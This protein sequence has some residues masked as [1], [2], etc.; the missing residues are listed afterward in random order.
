MIK[1]LAGMFA[2]GIAAAAGISAQTSAPPAL[3]DDG[4]RFVAQL[5]LEPNADDVLFKATGL[6]RSNQ[7]METVVHA[8]LGGDATLDDWANL[9]RALT[10][11][12]EL[13]TQRGDFGGTI[14]YLTLQEAYYNALESDHNAALETAMHV[15]DVEKQHQPEALSAGYTAM[16]DD[17][18]KLGR[19]NDALD[20]YREARRLGAAFAEP[21][22]SAQSQ[23]WFATLWLKIV[24]TEIQFKYL[25]TARTETNQF[26]AAAGD[27]VNAFRLRALIASA[28][29]MLAEG[30]YSAAIDAVKQAH[31]L[32]NDRD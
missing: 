10:G 30:R 20:A 17:L 23:G 14:I 21:I 4:R 13:A 28:D 24:E 25:D 22:A 3:L 27:G 29:V 7:L 9:H 12:A 32:V 16:A 8:G 31:T 19:G 1:T 5:K 18:R 11:Q 6:D 26:L 15:L 2:L